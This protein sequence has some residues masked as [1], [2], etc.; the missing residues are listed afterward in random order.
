MRETSHTGNGRSLADVVT[1]IKNEFTDFVHT[2]AAMALSEIRENMK[3]MKSSTRYLLAGAVLLGTAYFLLT[4]A[5]VTL[6]AAAFWDNPY[7]WFL[8]FAAVGLLWAILGSVLAYLAIRQ[9][10]IRGLLP[11]RTIEVL[12]RDKVWL[13][14][15][16]SHQ[17]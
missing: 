16:A 7:H 15:E 3:W 12:K 9:F 5:V 10:R 17:V 11:R 14:H 4:I 2:R 8:G 6:V 1:E 13:Q